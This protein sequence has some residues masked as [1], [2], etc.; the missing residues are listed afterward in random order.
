MTTISGSANTHAGWSRTHSAG[1]SSSGG[2]SR[3]DRMFSKVD[4]DGSGSVDK[5]ELQGM[6]DKIAE[7][8]GSSLGSADDLM[9][10]MD[11]DGNGSLS[12]D[13]LAAGMKSL[14]PAP[15]S[16]VDF[17]QQNNGGMPPP[18]PP[19]LDKDTSDSLQKLFAAADTDGDKTISPSEAD[20]LKQKMDAVIQSLQDGSATSSSSS[21]SSSSSTSGDTSSFNLSA[22]VDLV[23]K[24]Y[25]QGAGSSTAASATSSLS[26]T[27]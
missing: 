27:A 6:L 10:K 17:A 20:A 16:T 5:S 23:L 19:P 7:K 13:E 2:T 9:S 25:A 1:T 4:A 8:T 26:V 14:M 22:F 12:K 3:A 15:S 11:S 18:P 21:S 24:Q